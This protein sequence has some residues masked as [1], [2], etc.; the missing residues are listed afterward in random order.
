MRIS[1]LGAGRLVTIQVLGSQPPCP[2]SVNGISDAR[3]LATQ[4]GR[5]ALVPDASSVGTPDAGAQGSSARPHWP[6]SLPAG[7]RSAP[8]ASAAVAGACFRCSF[9]CNDNRVEDETKQGDRRGRRDTCGASPARGVTAVPTG[10]R[11]RLTPLFVPW[12]KGHEPR[13][14]ALS[15]VVIFVVLAAN[16]RFCC[17]FARPPE[18]RLGGRRCGLRL[19]GLAHVP[20]EPRWSLRNI[21]EEHE[22]CP[23]H[24]QQSADGKGGKN[25][26]PRLR[27]CGAPRLSAQRLSFHGSSSPAKPA[28]RPAVPTQGRPIPCPARP[29]TSQFGAELR[30]GARDLAGATLIPHRLAMAGTCSFLPTRRP[31]KRAWHGGRRG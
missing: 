18:L 4:K 8:T 2:R 20:P 17:A 31:S 6:W 30:R 29:R 11:P 3:P 25:D 24:Y 22:Q 14:Q 28:T 26:L 21:G 15:V 27:F 23:S 12:A 16:A 19:G 1:N 13:P 5:L 10:P 7:S 9:R